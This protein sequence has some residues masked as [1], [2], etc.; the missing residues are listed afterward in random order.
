MDLLDHVAARIR[1]LRVSYNSGEGLSQEALAAH[2]KV[3][4]NTISRW[5]TGTYRPSL[6]DLERI[7]RFFGVSMMSFF[8][9]ELVDDDE[10]ENLKAL[11]RTARQLHPADLEELRKYAEF[12]R[13]R[14]IYQGKSRPKPGRKGGKQK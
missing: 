13:A 7:S 9:Q 4:P 1:D 11:L 6:K 3:A 5:E 14:G 12:R 10:D 8:P 2:L